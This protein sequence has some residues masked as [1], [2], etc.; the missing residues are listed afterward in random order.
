VLG[1]ES[2]ITLV[3]HHATLLNA[4]SY[5]LFWSPKVYFC[6]SPVQ[7]IDTPVAQT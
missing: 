4:E 1:Y 2:P 7:N 6:G 5:Y 3:T